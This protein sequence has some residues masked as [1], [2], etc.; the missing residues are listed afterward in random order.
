MDKDN[1]LGILKRLADQLPLVESDRQRIY[2]ALQTL[3]T[4]S[5]DMADAAMVMQHVADAALKA[6]YEMACE[7]IKL[8][9]EK[10]EEP[11]KA[12]AKRTRRK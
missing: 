7:A 10:P 5:G 6:P 8:L 9:S 12:P 4:G 3:A 1:A 2:G 11:K